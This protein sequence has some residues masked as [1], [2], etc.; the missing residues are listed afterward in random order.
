VAA[1]EDNG[2]VNAAY[3]GAE[4]VDAEVDEEPE[5]QDAAWEA[6]YSEEEILLRQLEVPPN[7]LG[8]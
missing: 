6:G 8:T 2:G 7:D 4:V 1:V 3:E 5:E